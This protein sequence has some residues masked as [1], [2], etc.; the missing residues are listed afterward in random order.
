MREAGEMIF[1]DVCVTDTG[2]T[3]DLR[4]PRDIPVC[5]LAKALS[6]PDFL[7]GLNQEFPK[8]RSN[9]FGNL[10]AGVPG[11]QADM[12]QVSSLEIAE[13]YVWD[14]GGITVPVH[15][16]YGHMAFRELALWIRYAPEKLM[17]MDFF[18]DDNFPRDL[19]E[20]YWFKMLNKR[21]RV[22]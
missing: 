17:C 3:A 22:G 11:I 18:Y 1:V 7:L 15:P 20:N 21:Y 19:A 10:G 12:T 2:E 14:R 5:A 8:A 6:G 4:I 13:K 9:H 16:F